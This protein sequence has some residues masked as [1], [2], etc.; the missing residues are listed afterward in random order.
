MEVFD[1]K[2][3]KYI[4]AGIAVLTVIVLVISSIFVFNCIRS[5]V[6]SVAHHTKNILEIKSDSE[7]REDYLEKILNGLDNQDKEEIKSLFSPNAINE[8]ETLDE[9]IEKL[10]EFY[11]GKSIECKF[12]SGPSSA[13]RNQG[14]EIDEVNA[15]YYVTTDMKE[16]VL[17]FTVYTVDT[18]D[19]DNCGLHM[20]YLISKEDADKPFSWEQGYGVHIPEMEQ[21]F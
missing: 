18:G 7:V 11:K 4:L 12:S 19:E 14:I 20:I 17:R 10:L 6:F 21:P 2:V 9:D 16:Y 13:V 15:D 8:V 3:K 1:M 5:F